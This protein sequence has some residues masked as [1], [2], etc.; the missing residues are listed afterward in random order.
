MD[1]RN[2]YVVTINGVEHTLLLSPDDAEKY[3]SAAKKVETKARVP[4]N[5]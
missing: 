2:E 1:I 5:K 4:A 3:G